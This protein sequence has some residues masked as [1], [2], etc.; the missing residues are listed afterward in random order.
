MQ[1][2]FMEENYLKI[3]GCWKDWG[4]QMGVRYYMMSND[5]SLERS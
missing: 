1:G 4:E 5:V 2:D 3:K